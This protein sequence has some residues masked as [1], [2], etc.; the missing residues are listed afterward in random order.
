MVS[1]IIKV[2]LDE[3]TGFQS[4][5]MVSLVML[6]LKCSGSRLKSSAWNYV[7]KIFLSLDGAAKRNFNFETYGDTYMCKVYG[8]KM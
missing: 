6:G 4:S 7:Q 5:A 2:N 1:S 8:L 3:V